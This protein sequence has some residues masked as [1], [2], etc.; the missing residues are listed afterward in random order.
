MGGTGEIKD[1]GQTKTSTTALWFTE[2]SVRARG[3]KPRRQIT[4]SPRLGVVRGAS[5]P[6]TEKEN[7]LKNLNVQMY[8][9][10]SNGIDNGEDNGIKIPSS[11]LAP[12][13]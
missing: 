1:P 13:T 11:I 9:D 3:R 10:G 2:G 7:K 6:S 12:G 4:W 8:P 5:F